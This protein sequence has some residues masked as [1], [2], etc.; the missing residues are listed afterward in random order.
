[1]QISE[2][3]IYKSFISVKDKQILEDIFYIGFPLQNSPIFL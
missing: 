2:G 1:M 3:K